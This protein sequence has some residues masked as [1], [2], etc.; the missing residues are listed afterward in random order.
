MQKIRVGETLSSKIAIQFTSVDVTDVRTRLSGALTITCKIKRAGV[1][2]AAT[3]AGTFT[4]TDV[5]DAPGVREYIPGA[6]DVSLGPQVFVFTATGMEPR[7]VPVLGVYEDPYEPAVYGEIIAGTLG[8]TS[9]STDLTVLN[10][11][12]HRNAWI[13]FLDGNNAN[14]INQIG[15]VSSAVGKVVTLSDGF[16]LPSLPVAGDKFRIITK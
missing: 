13:W 14:S 5:A 16:S 4:G 15:A 1:V 6:N 7:E 8:V 9:F 3:G 2:E 10:T 11:N 12:Q